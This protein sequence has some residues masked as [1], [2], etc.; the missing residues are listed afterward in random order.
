M[1]V[2]GGGA[3]VVETLEDEDDEALVED[4]VPCVL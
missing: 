2:D 4:S 3:D 1:E